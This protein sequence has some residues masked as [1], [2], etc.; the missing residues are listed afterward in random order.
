MRSEGTVPPGVCAP[1]G[2]GREPRAS[3]GPGRDPPRAPAR[4]APHARVSSSNS[5][6]GSRPGVFRSN[7]VIAKRNTT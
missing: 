3:T 1:T 4:T 5:S 2:H 7:R 6:S